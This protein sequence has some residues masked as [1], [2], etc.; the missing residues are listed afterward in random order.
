MRYCT[1]CGKEVFDE[2]V[3]CVNCGC[4]LEQQAHP[5]QQ[6]QQTPQYQQ[7]QQNTPVAAFNDDLLTKLSERVKV[8]GIIW[9]IIA[10][11]QIIIGLCGMPFTIIVGVLNIISAI[12]DIKFSGTVLSNPYGIVNRYES[13]VS[14]IVT[15][16][17]NL[18]IGGVI[19]IVGSIYYFVA[20]RGF[21]MENKNHF[22]KYDNMM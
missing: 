18:I 22:S 16:I 13:L 19:G 8:N 1:R 17:Y 20:I 4:P 9:I 6:L 2:A 7:F 11:F 21:V 15:L 5:Y 14:P 10:A 3:I 12:N